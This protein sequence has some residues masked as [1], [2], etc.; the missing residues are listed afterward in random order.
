VCPRR[1][2]GPSLTWN[3]PR[4]IEPAPCSVNS[5]SSTALGARPS[6]MTGAH[7]GATAASAVSVLGIMPPAITPLSVIASTSAAL[8]A[9]TTSPSRP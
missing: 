1:A 5:S 2:V 9:V 6:T 4:I 7:A 3:A 8:R